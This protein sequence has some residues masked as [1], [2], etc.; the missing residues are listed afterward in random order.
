MKTAVL[1]LSCLLLILHV[2]SC[3]QEHKTIIKGSGKPEMNVEIF[4][5]TGSDL[6]SVYIGEQ[7][8][9]KIA[10]NGIVE[11]QS[12]PSFEMQDGA[13]FGYASGV[14]NGMQEDTRRV[15]YCGTGVEPAAVGD[16]QFDIELMDSKFGYRLHWRPH[17]K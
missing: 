1:N 4:N 14:I 8:V 6:D 2:C 9:G 15:G 5:K 12:C 17:K 16:H 10:K 3:A 11:V 7:Y 13:P